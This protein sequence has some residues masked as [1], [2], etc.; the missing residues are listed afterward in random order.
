MVSSEFHQASNFLLRSLFF[1]HAEAKNDF[2]L[3]KVF[4]SVT[5][6]AVFHSLKSLCGA[7][8]C[9]I[10]NSGSLYIMGMLFEIPF[11]K[12]LASGMENV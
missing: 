9:R 11:V 6:T 1:C 10:L 4:M 2:Y 5:P 12:V 8:F 3:D 7:F